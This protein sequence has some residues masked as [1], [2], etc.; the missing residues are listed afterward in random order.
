M[1]RILLI[2]HAQA[3]GDDGL[4]PGLSAVG[5]DEAAALVARLAGEGIAEVLHGP[6]RRARETAELLG[7]R[8]GL[9]TTSTD[10]LEDRTPV[11]SA[12]RNDDYPAHAAKFLGAVPPDERDEDGVALTASWLQL[13]DRSTS[14]QSDSARTRVF[15]THAFVI[16][17]FV[18]QVLGAPPAA[19]ML[20]PVHNASITELTLR[21][22]GAYALSGFNDVG[23]LRR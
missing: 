13:A 2:R 17:W 16:G 21:P 7:L 11:P 23:H 10:L 15:V 8:L 5:M 6:R 19:W 4:D 18:R 22:S 9:P 14:A 1:E 20:L 12:S 3:N